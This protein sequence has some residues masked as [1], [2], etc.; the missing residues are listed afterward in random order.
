LI[1]FLSKLVTNFD[2]LEAK[3]N[4]IHIISWFPILITLVLAMYAYKAT[5]KSA[6]MDSNDYI[7]IALSIAG[8]LVSLRAYAYCFSSFLVMPLM[9]VIIYLFTNK[10]PDTLGNFKIIKKDLLYKST[11]I[12][13]LIFLFS[14]ACKNYLTYQQEN[15]SVSTS[16]GSFKT[17]NAYAMGYNSAI[18]Y[19]KD[20]VKPED[21]ITIFPEETLINFLTRHISST[22]KVQFMDINNLNLSDSEYKK[23]FKELIN[24]EYIFISNFPY[25]LSKKYYFGLNYHRQIADWIKKNYNLV[26][27][28]GNYEVTY[29]KT[30]ANYGFLI[31]KRK[32]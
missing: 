23:T 1:E 2:L 18:N 5:I 26:A 28:A 25:F 14:F 13:L 30:S 19:I 11:I 15:Y 7:F 6:S 32:K 17:F 21:K 4:H 20:M 16:Y 31:Y 3:L 29:D 9:I 24:S 27:I 12:V 8:I 10:L 22:S